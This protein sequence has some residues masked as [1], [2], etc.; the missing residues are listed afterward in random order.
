[1]RPAS[2]DWHTDKYS[3]MFAVKRSRKQY[4]AA[5]A[6]ILKL[7]MTSLLCRGPVARVGRYGIARRYNCSSNR[8]KNSNMADVCFSKPEVV[9][10]QLWI[11]ICRWNLVCWLIFLPR[12]AMHKRDVCRHEVSVCMCV[13]QSVTFVSC[14]KTSNR[15]LKLFSPSG[16]P[17]ILVFPCQTGWQYK[18]PT[19]P[20]PLQGGVEC[21]WGRQK[22]RFCAYIW[23]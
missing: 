5:A 16:S 20:P 4:W 18:I 22:S 6:A 10:S 12:D 13:C 11:E 7:Y 21:R 15:I 23:L 9:I 2:V 3:I 8:K 1:M 17:T 19:G 14:V